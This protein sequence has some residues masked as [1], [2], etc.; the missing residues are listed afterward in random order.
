[1]FGIGG[2]FY[3][4][5]WW[6]VLLS[7]FAAP[8]FAESHPSAS[9]TQIEMAQAADEEFMEPDAGEPEDEGADAAVPHTGEADDASDEGAKE[10]FDQSLEAHGE[11]DEERSSDVCG[12]VKSGGD[13]DAKIIGGCKSRPGSW[14]SYVYLNIQKGQSEFLCGGIVIDSNWVV[15]AAHCIADAPSP[16]ENCAPGP[17]T[18]YAATSVTVFEG[19][20]TRYGASKKKLGRRLAVDRV[21][22]HPAYKGL[23][24][25]PKGHHD[26]ALLRLKTV[27][28]S[29]TGLLDKKDGGGLSFTKPGAFATVIGFG[30]TGEGISNHLRQVDVPI[31]SERDCRKAYSDAGVDYALQV[32]AGFDAGG[33]DSC[34]GDS[35]GP[36]YIRDPLGQQVL[37]GIVSWGAGCAEAGKPGIYTSV[38]G[39]EGWIRQYVPGAVFAL[40]SSNAPSGVDAS[41]GQ[42]VGPPPADSPSAN[43]EVTVSLTNG[44][45]VKIGEAISIRVTSSLTGALV[46]LNQ[47]QAGKVTQLFPNSF[48]ASTQGG[49]AREIIHAGETIEIPGSDQSFMLKASPPAARNTIIAIVAPPDAKIGDLVDPSKALQEIADPVALL[50]EI[51]QRSNEA[52]RS[53]G[54]DVV[55]AAKVGRAVG[56]RPFDIVTN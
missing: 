55:G 49:K 7:L 40:P 8:A 9:Q 18:D 11:S 39:H 53:R 10:D 30:D 44:A 24:A 3:S 26:I 36:L 15:T 51:T 41:L 23:C 27:A 22:R 25:S 37:I 1:M 52:D 45:R 50:T 34:G 31:F 12:A 6:G 21:V 46:V 28:K 54:V 42:F 5:L 35:G 43:G 14:P 17:V 16:A 2:M 19:T 38:A 4:F 48:S 20:D 33:K 29:P 32:C 47:D 56:K 13:R